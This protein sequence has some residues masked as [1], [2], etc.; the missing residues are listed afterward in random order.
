MCRL[1]CAF[2]PLPFRSHSCGLS[3][4]ALV[5]PLP[6]SHLVSGH[7]LGLLSMSFPASSSLGSSR[8][9]QLTC[10]LSFCCLLLVLILC[11]LRRF[12]F[13]L[14]LCVVIRSRVLPPACGL[15]PPCATVSFVLSSVLRPTWLFIPH[16]PAPAPYLT[17]ITFSLG[18]PV[19]TGCS[20][21]YSPSSLCAR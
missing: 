18:L 1:A 16:L 21:S 3:C 4:V 10:A 20:L 13:R 12:F 9:L 19:A 17:L 14:C 5:P 2:R 7:S 15:P 11:S 6:S 8:S